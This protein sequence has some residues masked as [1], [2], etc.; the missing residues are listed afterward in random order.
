MKP[1]GGPETEEAGSRQVELPGA[2]SVFLESNELNPLLYSTKQAPPRCIRFNPRRVDL[3]LQSVESELGAQLDPVS[4][5]PGFYSFPHDV[6]IAQSAAYKTG[7]IYGIDAASGAAVMALDPQPGDHVLDLC[8]APGGKLC[9]ISDLLRGRGSVTGVDI[10]RMR[11]AAC[12]TMLRKYGCGENVRLFVADGTLFSARP[13]PSLNGALSQPDHWTRALEESGGGNA[14]L[15]NV[16]GKLG[17][18]DRPIGIVES[19]LQS[20]VQHHPGNHPEE[21]ETTGHHPGNHSGNHPRNHPRN[22]PG[23]VETTENP[24][25]NHPGNLRG[26]LGTTGNNPGNLEPTGNHPRNDFGNLETTENP[27]GNHPGNLP[28]NLGPG[29]L[30]TVGNHPENRP[31]NL[32]TT[33][34]NHAGSHSRDAEREHKAEEEQNS[35]GLEIFE[36]AD[37]QKD[38]MH[39]ISCTNKF[40]EDCDHQQKVPLSDS[41]SV[42]QGGMETNSRGGGSRG[43]NDDDDDDD[44]KHMPF[45]AGFDGVNIT[46]LMSDKYRLQEVKDCTSSSPMGP[47]GSHS[48]SLGSCQ[49]RERGGGR[50]QEQSQKGGGDSH[51]LATSRREAN[52]SDSVQHGEMEEKKQWEEEKKREKEKKGGEEEEEQK[53][54]EEQEKGEEEEEEGKESPGEEAKESPEE[55]GGEG[56]AVDGM[57]DSFFL[58]RSCQEGQRGGANR[59]EGVRRRMHQQKED[60]GEAHEQ[61]AENGQTCQQ[62]G[63]GG[64]ICQQKGERPGTHQLGRRRG[65]DDCVPA[66]TRRHSPIAVSEKCEVHLEADPV[67]G[68]WRQQFAGVSSKERRTRTRNR[69][70][71]RNRS[72][73][74]G[75]GILDEGSA[76]AWKS[77][78]SFECLFCGKGLYSGPALQSRREQLLR[79]TDLDDDDGRGE[80]VY[81]KV[82]VDA[83]CTHDGS[84][85]HILK[86]DK[87]GWDTLEHR[88]L[89]VTRMANLREL[90][91]RLLDNGFR[92]MK[93]TGTLIYSTCSLTRAQNEDIVSWLL[94]TR[95][96][97]ELQPI[98][99]A[100]EWP[101]RSGMLEHTVR[102][103]PLTSNTSGLFVA[104]ITKKA[105][106]AQ[107]VERST[108]R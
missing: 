11:L 108:R 94:E 105:A 70:R 45:R 12:R 29:N 21:P 41:E 39:A 18:C 98:A 66:M 38:D 28:G 9:M 15:P 61:D 14:S 31:G 65:P 47:A 54:G 81:D 64:G 46:S 100:K 77:A 67:L 48:L 8:A 93:P 102:F 19:A 17:D 63:D 83:E 36:S 30:D 78:T 95:P 92:L 10:S 91:C 55:E 80:N 22:H 106:S 34:G 4:W 84:V 85:K 33:S 88:F 24:S 86:Y 103:D 59:R 60:T 40:F 13:P 43:V 42:G 51:Q 90:Q 75:G 25:G 107:I 101:H 104:K 3:E 35:Y 53:G 20:S 87:W 37:W 73:K 57:Q 76:E 1:R 62:E 2:F 27:C 7:G 69:T 71:N 5:L 32:E 97:A 44:D 23:N 50:Q 99:C 89:D 96:D 49:E 68:A 26:N 52:R 16:C 74:I 82:L 6:K 58:G 56:C 79:T 72:K